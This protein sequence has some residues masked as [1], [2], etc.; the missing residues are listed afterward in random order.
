MELA[1][2]LMSEEQ[3]KH[4]K[5]ECRMNETIL[6]KTV[7]SNIKTL[8]KDLKFWKASGHKDNK[9]LQTISDL[10]KDIKDEQWKLDET[11]KRIEKAFFE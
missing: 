2:D 8:K 1:L 6:I 9:T 3:E 4:W 10:E 11:Q 7:T 5:E